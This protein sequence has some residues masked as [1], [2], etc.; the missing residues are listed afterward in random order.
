MPGWVDTSHSSRCQDGWAIC[1]HR[2]VGRRIEPM[3]NR[4]I[5]IRYDTHSG[6]INSAQLDMSAMAHG[7]VSLGK[8]ALLARG[9]LR[10]G[11]LSVLSQIPADDSLIVLDYHRIGDA[12][13]D[14]FDPGVFSATGEQ[15][16]EQISYL[17]R[18]YRLVTLEEALAPADGTSK[19]KTR[20]GRVLITFDDG[21]RDN[22]DIAYPILRTHGVQGVFF[23]CPSLVGSSYVPWWDCIAFV[24][25]T[26]RQRRFT[27][28]YPG[29]LEVDMD[30]DGLSK[31]VRT[32]LKEYK[33]PENT[34]Q[35]RFIRELKEAAQGEEAPA[36][37]RR[38]LSWDEA[39][40]M[41]RGG[42]AIGS[43][44]VSHCVL[45]QMTPEAQFEELSNSRA[46][47]KSQLGVEV[48]ALAYPV[49]S[50]QSF[51]AE[52]QRLAQEAGYRAAFSYYGG[53]NRAG[54]INPYDFKRVHADLQSME[55][56]QVQMGVCRLT[57]KCWP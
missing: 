24:M 20:R 55:R 44:T 43:H 25:R 54:A 48:D 31:S 9:L 23:L 50:E 3:L 27:L 52:T 21:Y 15:F 49:G 39:R 47:L 14:A 57:G 7:S 4:L 37:S 32:V 33:R 46:V 41:I 18:K 2:L 45:S 34:D 1:L 56:F 22:Y 40:E 10:S 12:E 35:A 16:D 5:G 36:T 6:F 8:R 19:S 53:T 51:S 11:A 30:Q 38:F 29:E 28:R 42:M 13:A 17:K 26:A